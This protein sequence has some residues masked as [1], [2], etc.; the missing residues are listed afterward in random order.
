[1]CNFS[2]LLAH[3]VFPACGGEKINAVPENEKLLKFLWISQVM[4]ILQ[5]PFI[6]KKQECPYIKE[7]VCRYEYF[8]AMDLNSEEIDSLLEQ[9]WRKFGIYYFR[10]NCPDC[11]A[12][13]PVRIDVSHFEPSKSQKKIIRKGQDITTFYGPLTF[14][15]RIYDIYN[16]HSINRFGHETDVEDF[17]SSF[18]TSSC[19]SMQSEYYLDDV[20]VAAGFLDRGV[21]SLS[22]VYFVFD[23]EYS[24]FRLGT[25]SIIR[26]IEYAASLGLDYYYLGYWVR[27]NRSMAYKNRFFP[28][29]QYD[30][31]RGAWEPVE[32]E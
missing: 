12:C 10:P 16:D 28:H 22:S 7:A 19:P 4:V 11:S 2:K 9:G 13:V 24:K 3:G 26:E 30:W 21:R 29:E 1:M 15:Q 18:Y 27:E 8:F 6:S 17:L 31:E 5:E 20:M 25:L 14:K 23:T 32:K